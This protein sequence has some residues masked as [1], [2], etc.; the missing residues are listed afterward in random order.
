MKKEVEGFIEELESLQQNYFEM[1]NNYY[2]DFLNSSQISFDTDTQVIFFENGKDMKVSYNRELLHLN[3]DC[4]Q[5]SVLGFTIHPKIMEAN[6][7]AK[8]F[9]GW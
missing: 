9:A 6:L 5:L 3:R 2:L 4:R 1:W 8:K 7:L